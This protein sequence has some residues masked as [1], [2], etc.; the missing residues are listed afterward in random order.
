MA[1]SVVDYIFRELAVSY[2]GREDLAHAT[3]TDLLP[4]IIGNGAD[5]SAPARRRG[6]PGRR[7]PGVLDGVQKVASNGFLRNK[8][9]VLEGGLSLAANGSGN[10]Q[11]SRQWSQ[12]SRQ[13]FRTTVFGR[14][15]C[16]R[17]RRIPPAAGMAAC[18]PRNS[19]A[20]Q[21]LSRYLPRSPRRSTSSSTGSAKRG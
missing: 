19:G 3:G 12:R 5:E 7:R 9:A 14:Q 10:G 13:R 8:F 4:D 20:G 21:R 11:W 15:A 2:L 1:T 6:R 17:F 16:R 18:R